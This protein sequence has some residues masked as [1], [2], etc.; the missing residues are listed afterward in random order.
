METSID[1]SALNREDWNSLLNNYSLHDVAEA[2]ITGRLED[3][4]LHV[5]QW[6][7]DDRYNNDNLVFDN[8]M[9]IRIWESKHDTQM[10]PSPPPSF[11]GDHI[12]Q[13]CSDGSS[14]TD[15]HQWQLRGVLDVKAKSSSSWMGIFN[16]RHLA[17]YA[18]WA[19]TYDVPV[20][21]TFTQ[22]TREENEVGE[23]FVCPIQPWDG[24]EAYVNH[25]DRETEHA[26]DTTTIADDCPYVNR[27]FGADDGN[28]VVVIDDNNRYDFD[29]L[30]GAI[31]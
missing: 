12:E 14:I 11:T 9:D 17:H 1:P 15:I 16:L 8:R 20:Y 26:I 29:Y 22:I 6:G 19:D 23:T 24:Y 18:A 2:H 7:L 28:A 4:G 31:Q 21:V 13:R 30:L 27:T 10:S 3:S 5:E 25:Y